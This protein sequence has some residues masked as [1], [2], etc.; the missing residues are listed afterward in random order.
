MEGQLPLSH[1][2]RTVF[3]SGLGQVTGN[4]DNFLLKSQNQCL[5]PEVPTRTLDLNIPAPA[6]S[7]LVLLTFC[8][9]LVWPMCGPVTGVLQ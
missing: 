6:L 2:E 9:P 1:L 8:V 3:P 5:H 7:L 4:V